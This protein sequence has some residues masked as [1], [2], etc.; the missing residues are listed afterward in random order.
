MPEYKIDG[1]MPIVAVL[2]LA[3]FLLVQTVTGAW[4]LSE[5]HA[6]IASNSKDITRLATTLEKEIQLL[7]RTREQLIA[8][9]QTLK[10]NNKLLNRFLTAHVR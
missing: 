4:R 2:S 5:A 7:T 8:V 1:N 9:E 3:G 6:S 10:A